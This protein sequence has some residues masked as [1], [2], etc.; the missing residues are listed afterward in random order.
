MLDFFL[1]SGYHPTCFQG[2]GQLETFFPIWWTF[3]LFRQFWPAVFSILTTMMGQEI[4]LKAEYAYLCIEPPDLFKVQFKLMI[5]VLTSAK[6][7]FGRVW[8]TPTL[9]IAKTK[10][11]IT[12]TI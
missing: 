11:G 7:T 6:Q 3:S 2:C 9:S 8:K 1:V 4:P 10:S 12:Q 5:H